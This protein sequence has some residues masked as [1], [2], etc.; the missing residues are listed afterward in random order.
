MRRFGTSPSRMKHLGVARPVFVG[1]LFLIGVSAASSVALSQSGTSS[2]LSADVNYRQREL[3]ANP[4]NAEARAQLA[5]ALERKKDYQGMVTALEGH[6]DKIGRSGLVLLARA[7]AKLGRSLDEVTTLELATARY[8]KDAQ[9]QTLLANAL[10][11]NGKRDAAIEM[12]YKAKETNPKYIPAYD[13]LLGELVKGESR[14]EARDLISDMSKR[15]GAKPRWVSELCHLFVLDAFQEK[16]VETCSKALKVDKNNPMN[17]VHLATTYREQN[18]PDKAKNILIKTATRIKRS[19]PVQTALGDYFTEKKN[20]VDAYRWYKAAVKND[21]KSFAAQIGLAQSSLELQKMEDSLNAF[22]AACKLNRT[23][24][25][26]FQSGLIRIRNRG[27][28]KWKSQFEEA[29]STN[30]QTSI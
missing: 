4:A 20:F 2:A 18:E 21:S 26:E 15:F 1:F 10:S 29:I 25:R 30:C 22:V 9:L 28:A 8:A 17:A 13:G 3:E 16:A 6:K 23:A 19:E 5:V 12:Y 11:R 27:D 24:I 14:Q 7:Y